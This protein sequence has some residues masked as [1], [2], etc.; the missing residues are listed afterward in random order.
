LIIFF[1]VSAAVLCVSSRSRYIDHY[2]AQIGSLEKSK[3]IKKKVGARSPLA[4]AWPRRP[5]GLGRVQLARGRSLSRR[6]SHR[7]ASGVG[8]LACSSAGQ[9]AAVRAGSLS[10]RSFPDLIDTTYND[11]SPPVPRQFLTR[12]HKKK[13]KTV[14]CRSDLSLGDQRSR[15][16]LFSW[17]SSH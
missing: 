10:I 16:R 15:F 17:I 1:Q 7:L 13:T 2:I 9:D 11:T 6:G 12:F 5:S 14:A 8:S 4:L 3:K